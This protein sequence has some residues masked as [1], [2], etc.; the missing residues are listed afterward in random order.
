M[1][2]ILLAVCLLLTG[3]YTSAGEWARRNTMFSCNVE[4]FVE[5]G[6]PD[7]ARTFRKLQANANTEVDRRRRYASEEIAA[8][9]PHPPGPCSDYCNRYYAPHPSKK[10]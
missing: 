7:Q 9:T 10:K 4:Y 8:N 5:T 6:Q 2:M 3:C 1:K